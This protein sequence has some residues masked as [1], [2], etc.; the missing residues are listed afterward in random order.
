MPRTV[1]PGQAVGRAVIDLLFPPLCTGCEDRL[2]AGGTALPLCPSCRRALPHPPA[3]ALDTRLARI[4]PSLPFRHRLALWTFDDG[5]VLQRLQHALKYG[6]RPSLG[7]ALGVAI[8][9]RWNASG[10]PAPDLVAPIPLARARL[11]ERGYNQAERLAAGIAQAIEAPL[12]PVLVRARATRSQTSLSRKQRR[13]NVDGAF[14]VAP[15]GADVA[16]RRVLVVD[17]VMTTGA[18]VLAA[19]APLLAAGA[20]VDLALLALTRE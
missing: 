12:A 2:P 16:G 18:T 8:G 17:D 19:A 15:A 4:D 9:R 14:A 3:D 11:L 20:S 6:H 7:L 5:G 10:V 13:T 1:A